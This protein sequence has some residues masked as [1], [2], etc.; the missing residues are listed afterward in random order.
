MVLKQ[1]KVNANK[2]PTTVSGLEHTSASMLVPCASA[3]EHIV[4]GMD[5]CLGV[6]VLFALDMSAEA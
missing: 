1:P 6:Y 5:S 3:S 2:I 4:H